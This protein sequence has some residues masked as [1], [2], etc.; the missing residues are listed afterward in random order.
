LP[1]GTPGSR[2]S[3]AP[4]EVTGVHGL[5]LIAPRLAGVVFTF[6]YYHHL[7]TT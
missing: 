6:A 7:E 4:D 2:L 5:V 1:D 3:V